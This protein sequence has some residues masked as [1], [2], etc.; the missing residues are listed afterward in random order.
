MFAKDYVSD[1]ARMFSADT[2]KM[3]ALLDALL[4]Q[5]TGR[6]VAVVTVANSGSVP[7]GEAASRFASALHVN[8]VVIYV[9]RDAGQAAIAYGAN[10]GTLF[11]PALQTSIE[12]SLS[13][14]FHQGHYDSGIVTAVSAIAE[15]LAGGRSGG[16]GPPLT[17]AQS[18]PWQQAQSQFGWV[19][20]IAVMLV[21]TVLMVV[22]IRRR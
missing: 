22:L 16:H 20:W 18:G 9:E 10:T 12:Q 17:T 15:V 14:A 13:A 6:T 5:K 2:V 1:G 19:V 8:G 11:T 3:I 4:E 7:L 21:G